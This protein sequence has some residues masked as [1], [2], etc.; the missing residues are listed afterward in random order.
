MTA[1]A[2]LHEI[3]ATP[4]TFEFLEQVEKQPAVSAFVVDEALSLMEQ[5][6]VED[7]ERLL[8]DLLASNVLTWQ[9][10]RVGLTRL[11]IRTTLL[12]EALNGADLKSV[13][14][15]LSVHD[16]TL[17]MYELLREGM[18]HQ[19]IDSLVG[20]PSFGRLYISSPWINLNQ[21]Q[22]E[23]LMAAVIGAER[24]GRSPELLVITRPEEGTR[25]VAPSGVEPLQALGATVAL[26]SRLHTKLYIREPDASGGLEMA[27]V[28]SQNLTGSSYFELGIRVNGDTRVIVQL[29]VYFVDLM[30]ASIEVPAATAEE[31]EHA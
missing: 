27:I 20:R 19:F 24:R 7:P 2:Y 15:R 31:E 23:A 14:D 1:S 18:A 25:D 13:Y 22:R 17:H 4:G 26:N 28:G 9:G 3:V 10:D 21:R 11:G 30:N 5:S 16:T 8:Q 29:I 12:L 6:R